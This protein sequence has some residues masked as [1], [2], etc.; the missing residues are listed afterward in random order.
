M[1]PSSRRGSSISIPGPSPCTGAGQ[2]HNHLHTLPSPSLLPR[3]C[4]PLRGCWRAATSQPLA[5]PICGRSPTY[6]L[7]HV[8][9]N[10]LHASTDHPPVPSRYPLPCLLTTSPGPYQPLLPHTGS[11]ASC[12]ARPPGC[13]APAPSSPCASGP[14]RSQRPGT[15]AWS[16]T[17]RLAA[18]GREAS[19]ND[20]QLGLPPHSS[21]R[22][23]N[24]NKSS[25]HRGRSPKRTNARNCAIRRKGR[26]EANAAQS[27]AKNQPVPCAQS[28]SLP[29]TCWS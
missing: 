19:Q 14:G 7:I 5:R 9:Q 24:S 18:E 12:A 29:F 13:A 6:V 8:V 22:R 23:N 28:L 3:V 20:R 2:R 10:P 27:T 25:G 4:E 11:P 15:A 16:S 1:P 26:E 21:P 17:R